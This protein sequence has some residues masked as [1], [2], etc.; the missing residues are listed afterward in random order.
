[1]TY[2]AT[3]AAI[4]VHAAAAGAALTDPILDV[5]AGFPVPKDR[6]VRVYYAG[7]TA[8]LRMGG[9][10]VLNGELVSHRTLVALFLPVTDTEEFTAAIIDAEMFDFGHDL[11]TRILGD[12]QL[13]GASTDLTVGYLEP[14]LVTYNNVRYLLGLWEIISDYVEYTLAP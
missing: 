14:D 6:C 2:A 9:N 5:S 1:M 11:R 12:S 4:V 8:P 3:K 13:G 10:R 7:E